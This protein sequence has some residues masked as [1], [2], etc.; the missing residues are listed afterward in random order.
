MC[1]YG[2]YQSSNNQGTHYSSNSQSRITQWDEII[3]VEAFFFS[4]REFRILL[5]KA[6]EFIYFEKN[7]C[8]KKNKN[9]FQKELH[10]IVNVVVY[11]RASPSQSAPTILV[12]QVD[13]IFF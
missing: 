3:F 4:A 12:Y 2:R 9:A 5:T 8:M 6:V 11:S 13:L 7:M 1:F 10:L